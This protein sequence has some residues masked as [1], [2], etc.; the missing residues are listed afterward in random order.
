M[1]GLGIWL[2]CLMTLVS[3]Y[4]ANYIRGFTQST[5]EF[6]NADFSEDWLKQLIPLLPAKTSKARIIQFW[7][8]DCLCNRFALPH[9]INII[10]SADDKSLE[11]ITVIPK[12]YEN[13][14]EQ[15]QTLNP[16]TRILSL[17]PS[18]LAHW[19]SSPSVIVEG[20]FSQLLYIGPLG[21]GAFC[22]QPSSGVIDQILSKLDSD[23]IRPFFN[24]IGKGC[25]CPWNE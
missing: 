24:V 3:W 14:I 7:Q 25:F 4:Q 6:L 21:F 16:K 11:H 12:R 23:T 18:A 9:S 19:P 22:G 15:L 8:P 10:Q 13:Q 17:D 5:P 1:L 2:I 20:P